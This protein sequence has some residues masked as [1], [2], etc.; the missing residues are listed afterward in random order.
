VSKHA[1]LLKKVRHVKVLLFGRTADGF[2]QSRSALAEGRTQDYQ[3]VLDLLAEWWP[4]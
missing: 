2:G 3:A 1:G 4:P